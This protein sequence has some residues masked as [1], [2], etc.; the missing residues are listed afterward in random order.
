VVVSFSNNP[1]FK[2]TNLVDI[3][4]G[5]KA[6]ADLEMIIEGSGKLKKVAQKLAKESGTL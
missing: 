3:E 4:L 2:E 6:S 5:K 1:I